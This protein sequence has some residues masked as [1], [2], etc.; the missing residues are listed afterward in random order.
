MYNSLDGDGSSGLNPGPTY[1]I[2]HFSTQ[3][4]PALTHL[5]SP[6]GSGA[7]EKVFT[8]YYASKKIPSV[9][10][11]FNGRSDYGPFIAEGINI[12]SGGIFT[13]AEG[14]K[15]EEQAKLFGGSA[16]VAYD[17]NYHGAGDSYDNLNF[18]AFEANA[19]V[20]FRD[21]PLA[22]SREG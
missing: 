22:R 13:G 14:V 10:S 11:A 18:K 6:P 8:D 19:K 3:A 1:V 20:H 5:L 4:T 17:V 15:T 2:S 9:P 16:G 12:P 7:I 21:F